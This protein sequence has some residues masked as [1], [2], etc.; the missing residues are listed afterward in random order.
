M[1]NKH[2]DFDP[3]SLN[4]VWFETQRVLFK[5]KNKASRRIDVNISKLALIIAGLDPLQATIFL[6]VFLS[7]LLYCLYQSNSSIAM[8]QVDKPFSPSF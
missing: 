2:H 1:Y 3:G 5:R 8:L 4:F 7:F 6:F